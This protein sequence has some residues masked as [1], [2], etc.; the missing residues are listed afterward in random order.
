MPST[1]QNFLHVVL[2][3]LNKPTHRRLRPRPVTWE[4]RVSTF[5]E[6]EV[7]LPAYLVEALDELAERLGVDRSA[8]MRAVLDEGPKCQPDR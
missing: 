7:W 3:H 5:V 8:A 4:S 6:V 1:P 2:Y